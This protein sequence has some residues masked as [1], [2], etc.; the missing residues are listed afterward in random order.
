MDVAA[1]FV[2]APVAP[3]GRPVHLLGLTVRPGLARGYSIN[4]LSVALIRQPWQQSG[5]SEHCGS[6]LQLPAET[7][8]GKT[9]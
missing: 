2:P 6:R 3:R 9:A 1:F 7:I 5:I 8:K 4:Q